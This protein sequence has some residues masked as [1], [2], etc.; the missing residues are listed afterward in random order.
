MFRQKDYTLL[1]NLSND[2]DIDAAANREKEDD[3]Y[4]ESILDLPFKE[5]NQMDRCQG[6]DA[7]KMMSGNPC[8]VNFE[9]P[10][11]SRF[12]S[13]SI[14]QIP[15]LFNPMEDSIQMSSAKLI[16]R[17]VP[18][19]LGPRS[20]IPPGT[21]LSERSGTASLED[22]SSSVPSFSTLASSISSPDSSKVAN[23]M[24]LEEKS[25]FSKYPTNLYESQRFYN[26]LT[27]GRML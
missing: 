23:I 8:D 1:P 21:P 27:D 15:A 14:G 13:L 16:V 9:D 5:E 24:I 10:F 18:V 20:F 26:V 2:N 17:P 3:K 19:R 25:A 22:A 7:D 12:G 4:L 11:N 6:P